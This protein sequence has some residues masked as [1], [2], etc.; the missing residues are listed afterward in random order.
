M[1]LTLSTRLLTLVHVE[2]EHGTSTLTFAR[3][4]AVDAIASLS[5]MLTEALAM[6]SVHERVLAAREIERIIGFFTV[7]IVDELKARDDLDR[8]AESFSSYNLGRNA[9]R[10]FHATEIRVIIPSCAMFGEI[11]D[12]VHGDKSPV[13]AKERF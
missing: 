9:R 2:D 12:Y 6:V 11:L 1:P 3:P 5:A 7:D 8:N 13:G 4:S 10:W